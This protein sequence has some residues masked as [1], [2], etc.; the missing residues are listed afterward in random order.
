[1]SDCMY[2]LILLV[3]SS[4]SVTGFYSINKLDKYNFRENGNKI[5]IS[6]QIIG[7]ILFFIFLASIFIK[8]VL[9]K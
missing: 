9:F 5:L 4:N 1:M 3:I 2:A 7:S 8:N 6:I